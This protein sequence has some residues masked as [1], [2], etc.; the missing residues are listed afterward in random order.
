MIKVKFNRV[1]FGSLIENNIGT[2]IRKSAI[3]AHEWMHSGAFG[4]GIGTK[5]IHLG[6]KRNQL[7][8]SKSVINYFIKV[9]IENF[10]N[11]SFFHLGL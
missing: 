9:T 7:L 8:K 3:S 2:P 4:V 6:E 10:K 1:T 11:E 5:I